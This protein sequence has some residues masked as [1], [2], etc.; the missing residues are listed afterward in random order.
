MSQLWQLGM[1]RHVLH[2]SP[3][4]FFAKQFVQWV[5]V[6][7]MPLTEVGFLSIVV[8]IKSKHIFTWPTLELSRS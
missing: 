6:F 8:S 7:F 1:R 3:S 4:A 5:H 2:N